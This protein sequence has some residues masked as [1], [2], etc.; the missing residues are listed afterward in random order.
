MRPTLKECADGHAN[1]SKEHVDMSRPPICVF[2]LVDV[3]V[4]VKLNPNPCGH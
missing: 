1:V 3:R 2:V 4:R